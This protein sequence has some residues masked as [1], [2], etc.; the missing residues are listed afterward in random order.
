VFF[1]LW[2]IVSGYLIFKCTFMPRWIGVLLMIDGVGWTTYLLPSLGR[3][4]FPFVAGASAVAE[5]TL[6]LWLLIAGVN[7]DR[8]QQQASAAQ[9]P[10]HA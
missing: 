1:G 2:C 10:T 9:S 7:A 3:Q 6:M 8:W 4:L 5:I